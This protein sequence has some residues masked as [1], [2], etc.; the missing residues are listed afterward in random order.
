MSQE[1]V[2]FI[3]GNNAFFRAY[4]STPKLNGNGEPV[5][6]ISGFMKILEKLTR[7]YEPHR[8]C[9]FWDSEG[10][11]KRRKAIYKDYKEG[12]S[13][14][15]N[16]LNRP[17]HYQLD[18]DDE[19]RNQKWQFVR[20]IEYLNDMPIKQYKR[21]NI[22]ADDLI[23]YCKSIEPYDGMEKILVSNDKDFIQL[24]DEN[25]KL[26]RAVT[27]N[28]LTLDDILDKHEIH[29]ENFALA[30]AIA[31]DESDNL[32]GVSYVGLKTVSNEFEFLKEGKSYK[33]PDILEVSREKQDSYKTHENI[34]E[35]EDLIERNYRLMQLYESQISPEIKQDI[36]EKAKNQNGF[37]FKKMNILKKMRKDDIVDYNWGNL[38]GF[39]R[40]IVL[41][42]SDQ[43]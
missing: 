4:I 43:Q 29:P 17:D 30:R 27:D 15:V 13:L 36:Q 1:K 25:T 37:V 28:E 12:R 21:K 31:G 22:E 38:F 3:D 23:A 6:A 35:S 24:I 7:K 26:F 19:K 9:I 11:S 41:T 10:G 39:M 40:R 34:V 5:G 32:D 18:E 20:L 33:L 2:L 16:A 42:Q 14:S 8:I